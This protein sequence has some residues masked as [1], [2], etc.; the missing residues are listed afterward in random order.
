MKNIN[1]KKFVDNKGISLERLSEV[2]GLDSQII[3]DMYHKGIFDGDKLG[4]NALTS[5]MQ[6]LDI[7]N[8][9]ELIPS[10]K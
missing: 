4:V 2:T 6:A 7:I 5:L 1:L 10:M 8:I 3:A 9:N